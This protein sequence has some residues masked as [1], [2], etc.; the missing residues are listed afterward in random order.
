M[1]FALAAAAAAAAVTVGIASAPVVHRRLQRAE[2]QLVATQRGETRP[3]VASPTVTLTP[4]A[5]FCHVIMHAITSC[6]SMDSKR[7]HYWC[8]IPNNCGSCQIF[9]TMGLDTNTF[10]CSSSYMFCVFHEHCNRLLLAFSA[11]TL[12]VGRQEGQCRLAYRPADATA[13]HCLLLQ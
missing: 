7:L 9:H 6:C 3:A 8:H 2:L 11:L 5:A 10:I 12:L 1:N 13:T 4:S